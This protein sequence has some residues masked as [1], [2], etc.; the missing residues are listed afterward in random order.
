METYK[1]AYIEIWYFYKI[2]Q[3]K[4]KPENKVVGHKTV[5]QTLL[6]SS[7]QWLS[8]ALSRFI[9]QWIGYNTR[10]W[11]S[12]LIKKN[13][14]PSGQISTIKEIIVL[15]LVKDSSTLSDMMAD[16]SLWAP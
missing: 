5:M 6:T 15:N 1:K 13:V 11:N 3:E 16:L 8:L 7:T 9:A 2:N 4:D 12:G 14:E 10:F